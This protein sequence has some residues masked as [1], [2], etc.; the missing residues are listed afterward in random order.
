MVQR[1]LIR[2][3][4]ARSLLLL[5]GALLLSLAPA[6]A[7]KRSKT[8]AENPWPELLLDG[9]RKLIYQQSIKSE[10]DVGGKQGFWSKLVNI[11]AGP[12]EFREMMRPYGIAVDS[13]GRVIVTD[14]AI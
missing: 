1:V 7:L 12:P 8:P 4:G 9:G 6:F 3:W 5:T 10:R 14:P 2:T 13:R 11:V